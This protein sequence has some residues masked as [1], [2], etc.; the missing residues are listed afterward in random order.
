MSRVVLHGTVGWSTAV[1]LAFVVDP[2][3]VDLRHQL[4]VGCVDLIQFL[5]QFYQ[6]G[7]FPIVVIHGRVLLAKFFLVL[8]E[9]SVLP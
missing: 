9:F 4:L 5:A 2:V 8:K 1:Y 7:C 6:I 3:V